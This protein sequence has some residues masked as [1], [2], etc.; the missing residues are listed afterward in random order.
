[1][2]DLV[3]TSTSPPP[4]SSSRTL[5]PKS[6]TISILPNDA[7][8]L[9]S[10]IHPALLLSLFY[11][12]FSQLVADPVGTLARAVA[13]VAILQLLYCLICLPPSSGSSSPSAPSQQQDKQSSSTS[14]SSTP[15]ALKTPKRKRVQ[16]AKPPPTIWSKFIVRMILCHTF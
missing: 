3:A 1:M 15:G 13:P 7:A 10:N 16:F 8:R 12:F 4:S 9:Y 2:T 11:L 14:T 5:I 6:Q